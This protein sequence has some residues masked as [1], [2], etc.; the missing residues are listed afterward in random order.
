MT[1]DAISGSPANPVR[2][3]ICDDHLIVR[4]GLKRL[5]ETVDDLQ[6]VGEAASGEDVL[7]L[8]EQTHP[9][10]V[11][12]DVRLPGLSGVEATAALRVRFPTARVLALSTFV[13]DDLIFGAL[14][15][16]ACGYLVKD[17]HPDELFAAIRGAA[18]DEAVMSGEAA[19]RIIN[20][21][22][23][24]TSTVDDRHVSR[25][26]PQ[27]RVILDLVARGL[28]N[29]DIAEALTVSS[30][31]VKS[32]LGNIFSKLDVHNRT[33]A[34]SLYLREFLEREG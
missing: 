9:D 26:T 33:Q 5:L 28:S 21:A 24:A 27:E 11:L 29:A 7:A 8:F 32:H 1:A 13:D 18:R 22:L 10:V 15:A 16:G 14:R 19:S 30:K 25:L 4:E 12:M 23:R 3:F 34:V 31:T 20:R 2:V 17:V 6:V